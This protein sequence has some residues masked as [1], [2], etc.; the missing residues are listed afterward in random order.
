MRE[1]MKILHAAVVALCFLNV[2]CMHIFSPRADDSVT[3]PWIET[4]GLAM[5]ATFWPRTVRPGEH[6]FVQVSVKNTSK[7]RYI[8]PKS[9][10]KYLGAFVRLTKE[11]GTTPD[12]DWPNITPRWPEPRDFRLLVPG[13]TIKMRNAYAFL[14]HLKEE[15]PRGLPLKKT[16]ST[17]Y[18]TSGWYTVSFLVDQSVIPSFRGKRTEYGLREIVKWEEC[19]DIP[20]WQGALE[21]TPVRIEIKTQ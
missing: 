12:G 3:S 16:W 1:I 21:T 4:N 7:E 18:L 15:T 11:D 5:C 19:F 9:I 2:G 20:P 14:C 17:L 6:L 10:V 8:M 13:H